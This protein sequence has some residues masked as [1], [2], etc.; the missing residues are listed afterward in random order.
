[1]Q[2]QDHVDKAAELI[3]CA[4]A[5]QTLLLDTLQTNLSSLPP[6][7]LFSSPYLATGK[8]INDSWEIY[9]STSVSKLSTYARLDSTLRVHGVRAGYRKRLHPTK[10]GLEN[11]NSTKSRRLPFENS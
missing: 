5:L 1:M 11:G 2:I 6:S 10:A 4:F 8:R 3:L 9:A 7:A